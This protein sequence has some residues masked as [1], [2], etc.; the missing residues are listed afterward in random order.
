TNRPA[1]VQ[2]VELLLERAL[3]EQSKNRLIGYFNAA[4]PSAKPL[5]QFARLVFNA[6]PVVIVETSMPFVEETIGEIVNERIKPPGHLR[7]CSAVITG[8]SMT[9]DFTLPSQGPALVLMPLQVSR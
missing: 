6:S 9:L 1:V 2:M 5:D 8:D 3:R 4:Q 7:V